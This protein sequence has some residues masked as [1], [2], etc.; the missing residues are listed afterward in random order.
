MPSSGP[1]PPPPYGQSSG[2]PPGW[3]MPP[4]IALRG[5]APVQAPNAILALVLTIAGWVVGFLPISWIGFFVARA[6]LRDYPDCAMSKVAYWIGVASLI[7]GAL[8]LVIIMAA[9]VL[10]V[11]AGSAANCGST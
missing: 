8:V 5:P 3:N 4:P 7:L 1:P 9:I 6:S 10:A 2:A 11:G